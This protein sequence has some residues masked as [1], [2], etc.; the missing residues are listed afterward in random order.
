[1]RQ[2]REEI[3][4]LCISVFMFFILILIL[5]LVGMYYMHTGISKTDA[6]YLAKHHCK[7]IFTDKPEITFQCDN[8]LQ[9]NI[10]LHHPTIIN[11]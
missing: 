7:S 1:M 11:K 3:K 5:T 8:Q 6:D 9:Y 2:L 4:W 10:T